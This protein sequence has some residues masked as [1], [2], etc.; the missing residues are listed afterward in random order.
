MAVSLTCSL[1]GDEW[2]EDTGS[3]SDDDVC[4]ACDDDMTPEDRAEYRI[5]AARRHMQ[6]ALQAV[7]IIEALCREHIERAK[8]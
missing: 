4:E 2:Q 1:C 5:K 7:P 6:E 8:E 3:A